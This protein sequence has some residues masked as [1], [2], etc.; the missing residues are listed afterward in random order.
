MDFAG[1]NEL[2]G[3]VAFISHSKNERNS[4]SVFF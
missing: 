2:Y 1:L 4:S 3:V